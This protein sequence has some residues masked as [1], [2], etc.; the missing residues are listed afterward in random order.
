MHGGTVNCV[1]GLLTVDPPDITSPLTTTA[2]QTDNR[3]PYGHGNQ[4]CLPARLVGR[5]LDECPLSA[6]PSLREEVT[7]EGAH[8]NNQ[9]KKK[10]VVEG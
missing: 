1:A 5:A 7:F 3:Q 8:H 9:P 2:T 6:V 4:P 10:S